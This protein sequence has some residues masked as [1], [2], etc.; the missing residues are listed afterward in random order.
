MGKALQKKQKQK[1]EHPSPALPSVLRTQGRG[2][3]QKQKPN[4]NPN[5]NPN[6]KQRQ[7]LPSPN[8]S[9]ALRALGR[10]HGLG[11][12]CLPHSS[13][14]RGLYLGEQCGQGVIGGLAF[15]LQL[16]G[17]CDAVTQCWLGDL[18]DVVRG[19]KIAA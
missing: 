2:L 7:R 1:P 18:A 3:D 15:D 6:P 10:G 17:K 12:G 16:R 14:A 13:L 11:R 8:R 19:D 5:P 9:G 4:P